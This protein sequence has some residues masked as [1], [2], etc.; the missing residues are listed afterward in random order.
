M[1]QWAIDFV[2]GSISGTTGLVLVYPLEVVKTRM[3][4]NVKEY[5]NISSSFFKIL[6]EEKV[7]GLYKGLSAT[8]INS[9]PISALIFSEYY[10]MFRILDKNVNNK[11]LSRGVKQYM[12]GMYSGL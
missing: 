1:S 7:F 4:I 5:K 8:I 12:A 6:R 11:S 10:R 3:Q 9:L 2:S